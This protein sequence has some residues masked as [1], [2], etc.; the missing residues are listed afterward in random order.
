MIKT[1]TG[2]TVLPVP[3]KEILLPQHKLCGSTKWLSPIPSFILHPGD[4]VPGCGLV[5][6]FALEIWGLQSSLNPANHV[7][8]YTLCG[9]LGMSLIPSYFFFPGG[10]MTPLR[11]LLERFNWNVEMFGDYNYISLLD[12]SLHSLL[13]LAGKSWTAPQSLRKL[14]EGTSGCCCFMCCVLL[15]GKKH[16]RQTQK[17]TAS[18]FI[19]DAPFDTSPST[20]HPIQ[21]RCLQ[22]GSLCSE[23]CRGTRTQARDAHGTV[24]SHLLLT[25]VLWKVVPYHTRV[26]WGLES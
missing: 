16:S 17:Q 15:K 4:M 10:T 14:Q 25:T 5:F 21:P 12:L 11:V 1:L 3:A 8:T 2:R 26:N 7:L 19:A 24:N 22:L 20:G 6:S 9:T 18:F 13:S 23:R